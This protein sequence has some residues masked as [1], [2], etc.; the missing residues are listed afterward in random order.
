MTWLPK[1][2][3]FKMKNLASIYSIKL[4]IIQCE[5]QSEQLSLVEIWKN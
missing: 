4:M 2:E 1:L 5:C 3:L